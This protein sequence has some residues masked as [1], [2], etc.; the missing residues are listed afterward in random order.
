MLTK[1]DL[2]LQDPKERDRSGISNN[3]F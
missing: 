1:S 3:G 2:G